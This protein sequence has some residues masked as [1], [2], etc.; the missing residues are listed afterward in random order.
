MHADNQEI[1]SLEQ[2]EEE[3]SLYQK[4]WMTIPIKDFEYTLQNSVVKN[5]RIIY[6]NTQQNMVSYMIFSNQPSI[7]EVKTPAIILS[8]NESKYIKLKITS[9]STICKVII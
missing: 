9:P 4:M 5:I 6:K 7:V 1:E 2:E 3:W 8:F